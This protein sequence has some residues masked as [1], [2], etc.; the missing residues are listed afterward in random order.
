M[1]RRRRRRNG[2]MKVADVQSVNSGS[3]KT[4]AKAIYL[5]CM[6]AA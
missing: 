3:E 1:R 2:K 6:S 5:E 4:K